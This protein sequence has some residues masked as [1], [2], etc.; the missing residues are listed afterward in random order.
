MLANNGYENET[1]ILFKVSS[2]TPPCPIKL[3]TYGP[4][5]HINLQTREVESPKEVVVK[6]DHNSDV[7]YF[8]VD[9]Y[10]D[11]MD[12]STTNCVLVYS[13]N[14]K[15]YV[16]P[17]PYY[18]TYSLAGYGKII[19]PWILDE[20]VTRE[21]GAVEFSFRFYQIEG[22]TSSNATI[23]YSLQTKPA[24]FQ[25]QRGLDAPV[26]DTEEIKQN[27]YCGFLLALLAEANKTRKQFS[28]IIHEDEKTKPYNEELIQDEE[29]EEET[30]VE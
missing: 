3:P 12:L 16:Y 15:S 10:L 19:L 20:T 6:K 29:T 5:Y 17:V 13:I 8:S 22:D 28:W 25:V 18:D 27:D 14:D 24:I 9:R 21:A 4:L 1:A 30:E 23:T 11:Y 7:F 26:Y 2:S